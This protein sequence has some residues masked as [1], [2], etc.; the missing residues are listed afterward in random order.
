MM[1]FLKLFQRHPIIGNIASFLM[2]RAAFRGNWFAQAGTLAIFAAALDK[3]KQDQATEA[4]RD[5]AMNFARDKCGTDIYC[6]KSPDTIEGAKEA[7]IAA[8]KAVVQ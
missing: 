2:A 4:A 8:G 6:L 7:A 5:A 3:R 1:R